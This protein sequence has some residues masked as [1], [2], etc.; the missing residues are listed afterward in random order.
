MKFLPPL[1]VIFFVA[2]SLFFHKWN[3]EGRAKVPSDYQRIVSMAPSYSE[4]MVALKQSH[5][6][7]G[8]TTHCDLKELK[9]ITRIGTFTN[10]NVEIILSLKPDLV[11]AVPHPLATQTLRLLEKQGIEVF[12]H[13]PDS[14]ND[15]RFVTESLAEKLGVKYQAAELNTQLE[16]A[17]AL[18]KKRLEDYQKPNSTILIA[19]AHTPLVVAG[20]K[21]FMA[22]I[23]NHIGFTNLAHNT[24]AAWPI[25]PLENLISN[26]PDFF[27]ILEGVKVLGAYQRLFRTLNLHNHSSHFK[28]IIPKRP[29][30]FSPSPAIIR[31]IE[32]FAELLSTSV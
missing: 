6:L 30:F 4:T 26:P 14:L 28:L 23:A 19:I 29:L 10:A 8:V 22:E 9:E 16:H 17:L 32:Y 25:W 5:R 13:Q 27:V 3:G 2:S 20:K 21:T 7:V 18:A 1:L 24:Q 12:A 31:D 15:I 11:L